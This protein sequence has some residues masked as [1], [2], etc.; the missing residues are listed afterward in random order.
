MIDVISGTIEYVL[1]FLQLGINVLFAGVDG[2]S[3]AVFGE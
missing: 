3:S 1:N 2:L